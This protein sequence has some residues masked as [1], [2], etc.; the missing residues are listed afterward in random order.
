M[1]HRRP[2]AVRSKRFNKQAS[3][4]RTIQH[5]LPTTPVR[6][7]LDTKTLLQKIQRESRRPTRRNQSQRHNRRT[8]LLQRHTTTRG[9]PTM[10]VA[11]IATIATI[12]PYYPHTLWIVPLDTKTL[13]TL[14]NPANTKPTSQPGVCS[15]FVV[16]FGCF[17]GWVVLMVIEC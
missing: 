17:N 4:I 11:T 1:F 12:S 9:N 10:T 2:N 15:V 16:W 8:P 6:Q 5:V 3:S 14:A 13:A 7:N